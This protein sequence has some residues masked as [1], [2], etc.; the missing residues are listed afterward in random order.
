MSK[1]KVEKVKG[2]ELAREDDQSAWFVKEHNNGDITD[3]VIEPT[4]SGKAFRLRIREEN[5]DGLHLG[6]DELGTFPTF[7]EA[8]KSAKD[9]MGKHPSG[10]EGNIII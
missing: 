7:D 3:V 5:G 4:R 2:F 10:M 8:M 9:W 6:H 1:A